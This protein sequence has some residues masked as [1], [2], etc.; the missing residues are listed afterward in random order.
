M[1][2]AAGLGTRLQPYTLR[3][4]KPL[5]PLMGVPCI[6][7]SLLLLKDAGVKSVVVNVHAHPDQMKDYLN[8]F[9]KRTG[10]E[11]SISDESSRLLG[12]AGGFKK[13]IPLLESR[14]GKS[15]PFFS[16]N[17]DVVSV[18]DLE[19]LAAKHQQLRSQHG[20]VMTLCLARGKTLDR[21]D[22]SYTEILVDEDSG[23]ITG[24]GA[25]KNKVPFYTGTAIFET[26]AFQHLNDGIPAEFSPE[27]LLPWIEKKKVGFFWMENFWADVGSP[28]LWWKSHFELSK[29]MKQFSFPKSWT[30]AISK[31]KGDFIFSEEQQIVDY[32]LSQSS[33]EV[34]GERYIRFKGDRSDV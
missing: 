29:E 18:V 16:L 12:S 8:E 23:L 22:G 10:L 1:V 27:V 26:E 19:L 21:L 2:L 31:A 5:M 3:T 7:Y 13:A 6:E 15:E 28:D 11:I 34:G 30:Q 32:D 20:V 17:S 4:P 25:K 9:E 24:I 14:T 33:K